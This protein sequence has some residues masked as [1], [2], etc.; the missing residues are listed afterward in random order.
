[1][2]SSS[3]GPAALPGH[4]FQFTF[5]WERSNIG[6]APEFYKR[7]VRGVGFD[8]SNFPQGL[9]PS[10]GAALLNTTRLF[11]FPKVVNSTTPGEVFLKMS[12]ENNN[13]S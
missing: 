7:C 8:C 5:D 9:I 1:M 12:Q 4:I 13:K 10:S 2:Y 6:G 11:R 3:V